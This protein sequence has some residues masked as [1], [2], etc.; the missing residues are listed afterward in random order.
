MKKLFCLLWGV[1]IAT[2]F[3][4]SY[5]NAYTQEQREAYAWAYQYGITTQPTVEAANLEWNLTRQAFAKMVVNYLKNVIWL[6]AYKICTFPDMENIT[7]DLRLYTQL[8]CGFNIM[9]TQGE[10]FNPTQTIDRAQ[11]WTVVSRI[12]WWNEYNA[13][14]KQYYIY[15]LNAL[16]YNWIMNKIDN[17][18]AYAKRWDVLIM[19]KRVYEK[20]GSNV[21]LNWK[22]TSAYDASIATNN[23]ATNVKTTD[24]KDTDNKVD[25]RYEESEYLSTLYS[26]SNVI[27]TWK[28]GTKYIYDD[29][30]LNMLKAKAHEKW[31]SD[32]EKYLA[33]EANYFKDWLDQVANLDDDK[34]SEMLWVDINGIDIEKL[35]KKEKEDLLKTIKK[36]MDKI[37]KDNEERNATFISNLEKIVDKIKDD[38]FNLEGKLNKTKT[39]LET[40]NSFLT[41]YYEILYEAL[42]LAVNEKEMDDWEQIGMAFWLM[43]WVF[44][45]NEAAKQYQEYVENWAKNTIEIVINGVNPNNVTWDD[46]FW[47]TNRLLNAQKRA[48]DMARKSDL[49]QVQSAIVTWQL[50]N[51]K[52]P[53][54]NAATKWIAISDIEKE[55]KAA[56]MN[57]IPHDPE[58]KNSVTWLGDIKTSGWEYPYL[59]AQ[60]NGVTNWWFVLMAS[61]ETEWASNWVVC[62]NKSWLDNWYITNATDLKNI[63]PCS[64]VTK[65]D[66]CSAKACTYKNESELRYILM[67]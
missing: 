33:I 36:W 17:P 14:G 24:K 40:T 22:Q 30:F 21:Y 38:K 7:P 53:G 42:D 59:V 23:N 61:T 29:T 28:D 20:F 2:L 9:W 43:W 25:D 45:Y 50:D 32:L 49:S 19:L 26:N 41:L 44:T 16:K 66:T 64:E 37:L 55:L 51:W 31:E 6:D 46:S 34:I 52:W 4:S 11:L 13:G 15:H 62:E 1:I 48:K 39:F 57:A 10:N 60:R 67:Y 54:M 35:N 18:Q 58:E 3:I 8:V 56:W 65:W 12:L 63:N 5:A 27:Y 47:E